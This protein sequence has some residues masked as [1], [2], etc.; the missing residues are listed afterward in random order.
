MFLLSSKWVQI[1]TVPQFQDHLPEFLRWS[2]DPRARAAGW[3]DS[4]FASRDTNR[5]SV[6]GGVVMCAGT[7]V[8]FFFRT[9]KSVTLSF[10][11]AEYVA[12][13]AGI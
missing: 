12:L 8:S 7:C 1:S 13:P 10:T 6:S 5:R 4:D 3:L 2:R 9:Q 11:E